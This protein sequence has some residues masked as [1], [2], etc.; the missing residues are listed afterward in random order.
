MA[1]SLLEG[2]GL[3]LSLSHRCSLRRQCFPLM[4][5]SEEKIAVLLFTCNFGG[6][7]FGFREV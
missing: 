3:E 1:I 2:G 5:L 7:P 6:V 4:E